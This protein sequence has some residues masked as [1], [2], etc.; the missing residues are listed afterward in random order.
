MASFVSLLLIT[1]ANLWAG[2][3]GRGDLPEDTVYEYLD[4]PE[5]DCMKFTSNLSVPDDG[6]NSHPPQSGEMPEALSY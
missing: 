3:D 5:C 4:L 6:T 2:S 1:A